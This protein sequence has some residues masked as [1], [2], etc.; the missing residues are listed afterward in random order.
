MNWFR[1]KWALHNWNLFVH[2]SPKTRV[3]RWW[4]R[5]IQALVLWRTSGVN[6]FTIGLTVR[7]MKW[8]DMGSGLILIFDLLNAY[9]WMW[10]VRGFKT[11]SSTALLS[12]DDR[13][14]GSNGQ[15]FSR[16]VLIWAA[17]LGREPRRHKALVS[18][19]LRPSVTCHSYY[20]HL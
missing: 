20:C 4:K 9:L 18:L 7:K 1:V 17:F 3:H 19:V 14:E 6:F 5:K 10:V 12:R 2:G 13:N 15:K 16:D 8:Q 11:K